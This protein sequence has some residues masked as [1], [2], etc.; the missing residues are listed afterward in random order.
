MKH[1]NLMK[2]FYDSMKMRRWHWTRAS[3]LRQDC[4]TCKNECLGNVNSALGIWNLFRVEISKKLLMK[5]LCACFVIWNFIVSAKHFSTF[6]F[7]FYQVSLRQHL[8]VRHCY[9]QLLVIWKKMKKTCCL[10]ESFVFIWLNFPTLLNHTQVHAIFLSWQFVSPS[11]GFLNCSKLRHTE[12]SNPI[13]LKGFIA[14]QN[15]FEVRPAVDD[16]ICL[17][18]QRKLQFQIPTDCL[19]TRKS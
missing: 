6:S 17:E 10:I 7:I 11:V 15:R 13:H 4:C 3:I 2:R 12:S 16:T 14:L 19:Q 1:V 5:L 9:K 18:L 8:R